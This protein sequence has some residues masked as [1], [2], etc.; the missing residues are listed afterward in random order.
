MV[1]EGVSEERPVELRSEGQQEA[2]VKREGLFGEEEGV[3][4]PGR[5][6]RIC[7]ASEHKGFV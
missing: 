3:L 2:A 5:R 6:N 1:R 4:G 7:K